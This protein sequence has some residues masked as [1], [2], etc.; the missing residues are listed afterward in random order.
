MQGLSSRATKP[1]VFTC[2]SPGPSTGPLA[3]VGKQQDG[4]GSGPPDVEAIIARYNVL[5]K[6]YYQK[7]KANAPTWVP[8]N[9]VSR[10]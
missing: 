9:S 6:E 10:V 5:V 8:Q 2:A 1:R 4:T 7:Q 3:P